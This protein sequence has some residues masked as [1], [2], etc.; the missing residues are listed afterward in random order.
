ME[1]ANEC[2]DLFNAGDF[3]R[4]RLLVNNAAVAT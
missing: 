3:L 1:A 2:I 4:A